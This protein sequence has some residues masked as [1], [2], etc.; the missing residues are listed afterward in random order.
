M[1][2]CSL[3][4][5]GLSS[6]QTMSPASGSSPAPAVLV[7]DHLCTDIGAPIDARRLT[8]R[9]KP[10]HLSNHFSQCRVFVL[11]YGREPNR[12]VFD[13]DIDGLPLLKSEIFCDRPGQAHG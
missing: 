11:P 5:T 7:I 2:A 3:P 12:P 6:T 13:L 4:R 10:L 8:L 9:P 1:P